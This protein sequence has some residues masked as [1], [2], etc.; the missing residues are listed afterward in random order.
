MIR[1]SERSSKKAVQEAGFDSEFDRNGSQYQRILSER[2]PD[3]EI[4]AHLR[5]DPKTANLPSLV[6]TADLYLAKG[7]QAV[8]ENVIL[9]SVN[10]VRLIELVQKLLQSKD[11]QQ[12]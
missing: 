2:M 12:S 8:N 3:K 11:S 9:K 7:I 4:L 1:I 5:N 6:V 10:P